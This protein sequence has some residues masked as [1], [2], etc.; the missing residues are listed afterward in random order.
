MREVEIKLKL[1][2]AG[3]ARRRLGLAGAVAET[4]RHF[5][6]NRLYDDPGLSLKAKHQLL[7]LRS[8]GGKH[9]LTFKRPPDDSAADSRYKVRIEHE[10]TIGDPEAVDAVFRALGF[11]PVWRY[12][13][14]RQAYRMT[15]VTI[16]L[17]ETPIGVFMELEGEPD[18]IDRAAVALG[19]G[20][21]D[22]ITKTYRQLHEEAQGDAACGDLVFPSS[23]L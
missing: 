19:F 22:Y 23:T 2:D 5:E 18:A 4:P 20:P 17:D 6:D 9:V 16:D 1:D 12:Q 8:I 21:A 13:K 15:D 11:Q 10:T 7:R 3:E 14:Y